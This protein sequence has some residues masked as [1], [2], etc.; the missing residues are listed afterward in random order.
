MFARGVQPGIFAP[1]AWKFLTNKSDRVFNRASLVL[2]FGGRDLSISPE[3]S[4]G[5]QYRDRVGHLL[6]EGVDI[7]R[8][9]KRNPDAPGAFGLLIAGRND[10]GGNRFFCKAQIRAESIAGR[11]WS[12][13]QETGCG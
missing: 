10:A 2:K 7:D 3:E 1:Q 6:K 11:R 8:G 13:F 12:I 5:L 9:A 4:K